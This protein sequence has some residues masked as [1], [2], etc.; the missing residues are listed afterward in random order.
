MK[1]LPL[2]FPLNADMTF[3]NWSAT[4]KH[5]ALLKLLQQHG[6]KNRLIYLY[7]SGGVGKT[8]LLQAT[9]QQALSLHH[10]ALYLDCGKPLPADALTYATTLDCLATDNIDRINGETQKALFELYNKTKQRQLKWLISSQVLPQKLKFTFKDLMTRLSQAFIF[11]LEPYSDQE[12]GAILKQKSEEKGMLVHH[13]IYNYL[14]K[15]QPRDLTSLLQ[16]LE[17]IERLALQKQKKISLHLVK[18]ALQFE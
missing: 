7:G 11:H 16:T 13:S 8:H 9:I 4:T 6:D 5:Q 14:L 3:A 2:P 18:E 12:C 1:Q 10:K 17:K 15:H